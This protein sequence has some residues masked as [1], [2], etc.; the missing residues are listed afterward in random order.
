MG[1]GQRRPENGQPELAFWS[2]LV[3]HPLASTA[4][5]ANLRGAIDWGLDVVGEGLSCKLLK[6][7]KW[8]N[9]YLLS[10]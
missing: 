6:T 3:S 9:K 2:A 8:K 7:N 5:P 10:Y 1:G 4:G